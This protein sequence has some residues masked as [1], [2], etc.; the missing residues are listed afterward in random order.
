MT[1]T[2]KPMANPPSHDEGSL[3]S[4]G[5]GQSLKVMALVA[6]PVVWV[7][8]GV[9]GNQAVQAAGLSA[10]LCL[11]GALLAHWV[12][13]WPALALNAMNKF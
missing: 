12:V 8:F 2:N 5:I 6:V 3:A 4:Q 1:D 13:E 10:L 11:G 9:G 7:A